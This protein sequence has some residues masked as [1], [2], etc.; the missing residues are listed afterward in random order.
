MGFFLDLF[1]GKTGFSVSDNLAMDEDGN[2]LM[3]L[4]DNMAMAMDTGDLHILSSSG[5][6]FDED[7]NDW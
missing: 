4:S 7:D 1:N 6:V 2:L 3:K 5:N